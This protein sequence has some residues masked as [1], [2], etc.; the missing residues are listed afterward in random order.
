MVFDKFFPID[1]GNYK[2]T[3]FLAGSARSGSTWLMELLNFDGSYRVMHEPFHSYKIKILK[4][5]RYLQYLR[6]GNQ[7]EK[8]YKPAK[9]IL[10]GQIRDKDWIDKYNHKNITFKRI[11]KDIRSNFFLFWMKQNFPEIPIVFIIRHPCAVASS[12]VLLGWNADL[13]I[14]LNQKDLIDDHLKPFVDVI[15]RTKSAFEKQIAMWCIENYVPLKQF[16]SDAIQVVF[17]ENLVEKP[18]ETTQKIFSFLDLD[19]EISH[20]NIFSKPSKESRM[21]SPINTGENLLGSWRNHVTGEQIN[22]AIEIIKAFGFEKIYNQG[23]F[24]LLD[25]SEVLDSLK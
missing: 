22:E 15:A 13:S 9:K 8:Y 14:C 17:Y 21:K 10:S 2:N 25:S 1:F 7:E 19:K 24:P 20:F 16:K 18:K 3:L 12:R 5:W 23:N 11:I 4:E 6:P